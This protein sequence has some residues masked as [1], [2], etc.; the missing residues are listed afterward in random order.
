MARDHARI[1]CR[2]WADEDFRARS[3]H[4][5]WLYFLL[6]SH[7]A[8]NNAG[9]LPLQTRQWANRCAT[10]TED[11]VTA[12]VG[13][14]VEHRFVVVD[15]GTEELLVRTFIRNDGVARQPNLLKNA[16]RLARQVES[17]A[18]RHELAIEL[19]R[20]DTSWMK[21]KDVGPLVAETV[22]LLRG[23]PPPPEP[24]ANPL[25]NGSA[26]PSHNPSNGAARNPSESGVSNPS[27]NPSANPLGMGTGLGKGYTS[28]Y[29]A[30]HLEDGRPAR[31]KPEDQRA[32]PERPPLAELAADAVQ[33]DAYRLVTDWAQATSGVTSAQRRRLGKKA[34]DLLRQGAEPMLLRE[35]LD[36][37]H[38][39][40]WRDPVS[41]LPSAYDR[42]RRRHYPPPTPAP[43]P[44]P[45]RV[46]TTTQ[47]VN[48]IQALK[49]GDIA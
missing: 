10:A 8:I 28:S 44:T 13:E 6:L 41:S 47:R 38:R 25:Q 48:A 45:S 43:D 2:I 12:A 11:T 4:A 21:D 1:L 46:P 16:A 19:A 3:A 5:Q 20:V 33:V 39:P 14:L 27:V 36:E 24:T 15:H 29:V 30:T 31:A 7:G 49:R 40:E 22:A 42:V 35:A 26:N 18:L 23:G 17:P 9:V 32:R 37:A 34:D